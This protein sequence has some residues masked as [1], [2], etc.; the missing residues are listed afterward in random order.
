[1]RRDPF[2][3]LGETAIL[4]VMKRETA[5]LRRIAGEMLGGM[6]KGA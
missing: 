1:M 5:L 3:G 4:H 2:I 6:K